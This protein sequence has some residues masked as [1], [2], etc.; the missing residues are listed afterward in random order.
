MDTTCLYGLECD[1]PGAQVGD[2]IDGMAADRC[3]DATEIELWIEPVELRRTQE[4]VD[5][6]GTFA[7]LIGAGEE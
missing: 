7:A 5:G 1:V 4:R 2:A 3:Q 6:R